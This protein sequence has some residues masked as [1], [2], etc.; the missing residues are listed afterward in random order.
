A[1]FNASSNRSSTTAFN[2]L[3]TSLICSINVLVISS[4]VILL[5]LIKDAIVV[6]SHSKRLFA[7]FNLFKLSTYIPP[8][9]KARYR[10]YIMLLVVCCHF[11]Q[12]KY[13]RAV[14]NEDSNAI[15]LTNML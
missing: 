2:S 15:L 6:A 4:L 5:F 9:Q 12:I 3:F 10:Q 13:E 14:N 1:S 7:T 11:I 8:F